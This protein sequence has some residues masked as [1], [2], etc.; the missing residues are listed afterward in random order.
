MPRLGPGGREADP[1]TLAPKLGRIW[2]E[3][4]VE[5]NVTLSVAAERQGPLTEPQFSFSARCH[6]HTHTHPHTDAHTCTHT[7][8]ASECIREHV[9]FS[10]APLSS[11]H[12]LTGVLNLN[13]SVGLPNIFKDPWDG[14]H[15][16]LVILVLIPDLIPLL[17]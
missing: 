16:F 14:N 17:G 12:L 5:V 15:D 2:A 11:P 4:P 6:T 9:G 10:T 8:K 7:G 13:C 3:P 1:H